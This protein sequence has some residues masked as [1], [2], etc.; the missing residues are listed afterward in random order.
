MGY[1]FTNMCAIVIDFGMYKIY[2]QPDIN[3]KKN[4]SS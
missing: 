3:L 4:D 2:A 1:F